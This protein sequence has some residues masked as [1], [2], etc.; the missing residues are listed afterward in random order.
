MSAALL[1]GVAAC[2]PTDTTRP[3]SAPT[4]TGTTAPSVSPHFEL[5][6]YQYALQ[7]K[8]KIRIATQEDNPPFSE[9][10][11]NTGVWSGFDVDL[12][13][14]LA[15]AIWGAGAGADADAHIEWIP[16]N[17]ATRLKALTSGSADVVIQ[18]LAL[19][20]ENRGAIDLTGA[21]FH[22]TERLL[23]KRT[24]DQV[25]DVQDLADGTRTVCA[26]RGS[27][28]EADVR[29]A[30]NN[31]AKVLALDSYTACL[32]ALQSGAAEVVA[33]NEIALAT[34]AKKDSGTMIVGKP[35]GDRRYAIGLKKSVNGDRQGFLTF[36]NAF[37]EDLVASGRW[38]KLY[39]QDLTPIT[40]DH[41]Q[42]PD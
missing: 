13:R 1:L 31:G 6:T 8:G 28:S 15:Q 27:S 30:T 12:A 38:A 3:T 20:D 41:K 23:V 17:P 26:Q 35:F 37:L 4:P 5:A 36:L 25:T 32:Q 34:L 29:T 24:N 40:G 2:T 11:A 21:Y 42:A 18:T 39:E 22:V 33:G 19:S 10:N 14:A 16:V 7:V 9:K